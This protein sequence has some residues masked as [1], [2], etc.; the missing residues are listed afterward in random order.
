MAMAGFGGGCHWCTEA[1]FQPLIGVA[2]VRQGFVRSDPPDASW[3]EAVEVD[4]DPAVI[5]LRDLVEVH[6]A[7]HASTADH[8]LRDKYRSA[9]YLAEPSECAACAALIA[10]IGAETGV[11]FITRALMHRGFRAS[12]ARFHDYYRTDPERP[13]CQAYIAPKL[14]ALRARHGALLRP[15]GDGG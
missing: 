9:V 7:T 12:D 6:L 11:A 4:F 10:E 13:F 8:S 3:S 1:V 15:E 2:E 5:A 14:A